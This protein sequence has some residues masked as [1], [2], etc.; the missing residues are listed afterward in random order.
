[1]PFTSR[2]THEADIY[3]ISAGEKTELGGRTVGYPDDPDQAAVACQLVEGFPNAAQEEFGRDLEADGVVHFADGVTIK[4]AAD[5]KDGKPDKLIVTEC[6]PRWDGLKLPNGWPFKA[7]IEAPAGTVS[8]V[9]DD[10]NERWANEA[11][12]VLIRK[13]VTP[14]WELFDNQDEIGF[15]HVLTLDE[16]VDPIPDGSWPDDYRAATWNPPEGRKTAWYAVASTDNKTMA[17]GQKVAVRRFR[18]S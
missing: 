1:M 16:S 18:G 6:E 17:R 4:P 13:N 2:L 8:I 3:H 15:I 9:W 11:G 5:T 7:T 12:D 10:E 14:A